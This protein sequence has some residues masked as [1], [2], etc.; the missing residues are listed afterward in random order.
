MTLEKQKE[1]VK[2]V[3]KNRKI[4][5]F[6]SGI[7]GVTVLKEIIKVLPNEDYMY[8][9][10]SKNNP[11]GDRTEEEV[12]QICDKIVQHFIKNNCKAVIIA[13]NTASAKAAKYLREKYP[14]IPFIAIEPA[15]KMVHD[16]AYDKPTLVMATKGTMES[17]KFNLLFQKYDNYKTYL[18]PCVGLAER[19][20]LGDKEEIKRYLKRTIGIYKGKVKNVVLGC[21]HYPLVENEIKEILGQVQ[22]FNGAPNLAKHLKYILQKENILDKGKGMIEFEDSQNFEQKKKRFL[23]IL[24]EK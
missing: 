23:E 9:S 11:Y 22:F 5:I 20:E 21:T 8:Y 7:G 13:C 18:L 19:I 1:R 17:E 12:K 14:Q 2:K 15:Y 16:Y 3:N 24:K 4:G 10:D 6:D